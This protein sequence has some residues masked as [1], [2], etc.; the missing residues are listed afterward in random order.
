MVT[1]VVAIVQARMGSTRLPGKVLADVAGRS[2]LQRVIERLDAARRLDAVVVATTREESDRPLVEYCRSQDWPV[3]AG[4]EQDVL[5]R[6]LQAAYRFGADVVVR[7]TS[8]CPLID[9][10]VVDAVVERLSSDPQLE[11]ACNF[12]PERTFPRG[13]DVEAIRRSTLER[14]AVATT[15]PRYR[16]HVTLYIYEHPNEFRLGSVVATENAAEW[17]WTVDYPEDLEFVQAIYRFFGAK[18]F[19]WQACLRECL[20]HPEWRNLNQHLQQKAA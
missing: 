7:I 20:R 11:Y 19:G 1:R 13:L 12:Y 18:S 5:H 10:S 15:D 16:E 3:Y 8:D 6:Y 14:V 4:S 17:R 2:M 9:P